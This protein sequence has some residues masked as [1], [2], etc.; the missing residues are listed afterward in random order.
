MS[1]ERLTIA[2]IQTAVAYF[3]HIPPREMTSARRARSIAYPR[4]VAMYLARTMTP[5]SYPH[6][7]RLFGNR[8]HTTVLHAV[9]AVE[10]RCANDVAYLHDVE[11]LRGLLS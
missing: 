8:D 6:I 5:K 2:E 7:G 10:K 3:Y 1:A 9:R 11:S 4:Q